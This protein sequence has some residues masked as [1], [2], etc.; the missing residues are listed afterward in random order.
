MWLMVLLLAVVTLYL[1]LSEFTC[2]R[3]ARNHTGLYEDIGAPS[4]LRGAEI[5]SLF[6]FWK[7][8]FTR[9]HKDRGDRVLSMLSDVSLFALLASLSL[10]VPVG[11]LITYLACPCWEI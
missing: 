8:L 11:V 7:F 3:L 9:G 4:I 5:G 1:V 10:P 2:R 6:D